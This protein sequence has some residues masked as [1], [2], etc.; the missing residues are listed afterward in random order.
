MADMQIKTGKGTS[1]KGGAKKNIHVDLTPMVDLGFLLITFFVFTSMMAKPTV[2]ELRTPY[3]NT[4]VTD[5]VCNSCALTVLLD[6]D[7]VIRYYEGAFEK[8]T[9]HTASYN[10]IREIIRQK[11]KTVQQVRGSGKEFVLIIKAADA[12]SFKNFIDITDEVAIND[13]RQYYIDE[14]T[15]AEKKEMEQPGIR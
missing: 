3:D 9:L 13:V 11:K 4:T 12:A 1:A 10:S 15:G 5:P 2:M 8:T 6:R 14:I 7:N